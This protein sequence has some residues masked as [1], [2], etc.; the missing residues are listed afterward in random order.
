M[1]R[2]NTGLIWI[3]GLTG[4]TIW[5]L[6]WRPKPDRPANVYLSTPT[7][8]TLKVWDSVSH[9]ERWTTFPSPFTPLHFNPAF[10]PG[11][12]AGPFD[13]WR[14]GGCLALTHLFHNDD[15]LNFESCKRDYDLTNTERYRYTQLM[16]WALTP[17]V[18]EAATRPLSPFEIFLTKTTTLKGTISAIYKLLLQSQH[19]P[20][21]AIYPYGRTCYNAQFW[22]LN[23]HIYGPTLLNLI[24]L[25]ISRRPT[26]R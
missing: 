7:R 4:R 1:T 2:K 19:S 13:A 22:T 15:P 14:E 25:P 12:H 5:D 24:T 9:D 17:R 10:P 23:G 18:R 21:P 16:H 11:L 8:T 20:R 3:G 26:L 6:I